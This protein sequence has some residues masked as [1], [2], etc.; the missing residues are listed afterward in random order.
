MVANT[1][2]FV[3]LKLATGVISMFAVILF[4]HVKETFPLISMKE[5]LAAN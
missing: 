1:F 4:F 3:L 5:G 2:M